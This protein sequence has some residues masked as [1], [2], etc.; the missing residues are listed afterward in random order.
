MFWPIFFLQLGF[1]TFYAQNQKNDRK[2]QERSSRLKSSPNISFV[3]ITN[4]Q[5]QNPL[6]SRRSLFWDHT[7]YGWIKPFNR[8]VVFSDIW[9]YY[10]PSTGVIRDTFWRFFN[11]SPLYTHL[12]GSEPTNIS[13]QYSKDY[14]S[15]FSM[16]SILSCSI[17]FASEVCPELPRRFGVIRDSM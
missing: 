5:N 13:R 10:I 1:L 8:G 11:W 6:I 17:N 15:I 4:N 14:K 7:R 3:K 16:T 9:C 12:R 2:Y